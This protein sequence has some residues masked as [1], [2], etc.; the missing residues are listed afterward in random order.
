M[1]K[2]YK[3]NFGLVVENNT[4]IKVTRKQLEDEGIRTRYKG[5]TIID[6]TKSFRLYIR[7]RGKSSHFYSRG[8]SRKNIS[9]KKY[10]NEKHLEKINILFNFLNARDRVRICTY[11]WEYGKPKPELETIFSF[12]NYYFAKEVKQSLSSQHYFIADIFGVSKSLNKTEKE[13]LLAIE[14]IDTHFPDIKT[15][16]YYRQITKQ[17]PL[18]VVFYYLEYEL[19]LNHMFK[20]SGDNNNGKLRISHYIQDGSFW[21][22]DERIEDKSYSNIKTYKEKINFN[23]EEEYYKSINELELKRIK[24]RF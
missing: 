13:P 22:G 3:Y 16:N 6:E 4:L 11:Y 12:K 10:R 9:S 5:K 8:K 24:K 1:N 20:N 23:N 14:V 2:R 7:S 19:I 15:F 18:I 21:V 17:Q